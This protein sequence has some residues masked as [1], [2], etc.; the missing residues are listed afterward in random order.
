MGALIILIIV[1]A[2]VLIVV[3]MYNSLVTS[4]PLRG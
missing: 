2:L 4:E 1:G 3:G